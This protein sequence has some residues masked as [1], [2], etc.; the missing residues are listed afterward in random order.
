MAAPLHECNRAS[1]SLILPKPPIPLPCSYVD[2]VL[3]L[4]ELQGLRNSIVGAGAGSGGGTDAGLSLE[5]VRGVGQASSHICTV[6]CFLG[7]LQV[8]WTHATLVTHAGQLVLHVAEPA[9]LRC[10]PQRKRLSLAVELV[11]NPA[12]IFSECSSCNSMPLI[13]RE[14]RKQMR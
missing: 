5:Q 8:Q 14:G 7:H 11:A 4:V 2:S 3:E 10:A 12:V 6:R 13:E 1:P 9:A